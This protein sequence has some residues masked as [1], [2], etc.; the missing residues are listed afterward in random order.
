MRPWPIAVLAI[1]ACA[2]HFVLPPIPESQEWVRPSTESAIAAPAAPPG[3][4]RVRTD[5][6]PA[7]DRTRRS[8]TTH[9]G[10]YTA[11][12]SRPQIT[13]FAMTAGRSLPEHVP[14]SIGLVFRTLDPQTVRG[15]QL[16]LACP[17][18][19]DSIGVVV[20]SYVAPTGSTESHFMTYRLPVA[21]VAAF[22]A[23]TEG[24]LTI[25]QIR[26]PFSASQLGGLRALLHALG[27]ALAPDAT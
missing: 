19:A 10:V 11:W 22:A 14:A 6:D 23:C 24:S 7:A 15:T 9:R 13:F 26:V 27:A 1:A 3:A 17:G 25:A 2:P 21:D 20:A 4:P 5:Y 12:V 18:R 8:V 16:I